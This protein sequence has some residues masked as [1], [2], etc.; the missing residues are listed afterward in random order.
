MYALPNGTA[1]ASAWVTVN[2]ADPTNANN[3]YIQS[4]ATEGRLAS[5]RTSGVPSYLPMTF[6]TGGS[7]RMRIDTSGNVGIGTS[8]PTTKLT[9]SNNTAL[10]SAGAPGGTGLWQVS[11][12][13]G[14]STITLDAFSGGVGGIIGRRAQGTAASPSALASGNQ[15]LAITGRGYGATGYSGAARASIIM[16]A[17]EAW[18]DTAQGTR[19]TFQTT[20]NGTAT[21][22]ERMRIDNAGNVGIGTTSP[23]F[24]LDVSGS[25]SQGIRAITTDT[26]G[27]N[28]GRLIAQ[29]TGGGGGVASQVDLR[30]GDG[31]TF[32]TSVT[33]TP[34]L[35]GVNST[36]RM[37]IDSAGNVL[38]NTTTAKLYNNNVVTPKLQI[39]AAGT[40]GS[41]SIT[42]FTATLDAP[43]RL[44]L[45]RSGSATLGT[46]AVVAQFTTLGSLSFQGYD[47]VGYV[48]RA[49][50]RGVVD[51]AVSSG[52]LPSAL[53]F[54][55]GTT[56]SIERM[57]ID[58]SG[59]VLPGANGTQNL[60]SSD[61]RWANLYLNDLN[62]S[63]GIGD[64]TIVE[65]E[66]D[67]FLYNNKSG[68]VFKFALIEVDPAIAPPKKGQ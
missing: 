26:S 33:N 64:Y 44:I 19:I 56:G 53:V 43:S 27:V 18:T 41:L 59:N 22:A 10:P 54:N 51:G 48:E 34:V 47:G 57:R 45:A 20:T 38:I 30:A 63:N 50:V 12:D 58:S 31:Y 2:N 61:L 24:K 32:L 55:T 14:N 23:S 65:G 9:I 17:E 36:E 40:D 49:S 13:S 25:G 52:T 39:Q 28:I 35:F 67:L 11:N 8:A 5:D 68:K 4:L 46:D 29:Y 42:R 66:E 37:R 6:F 62:L 7:E 15:L 3:M 60:G 1:T 16:L 21:A